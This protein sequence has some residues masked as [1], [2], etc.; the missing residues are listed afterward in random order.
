MVVKETIVA[1]LAEWGLA[2][3]EREIEQLVPAYENLLRWQG[4]LEGMM[5]SKKLVEGMTAPASEP[6]LIHAIERT[7]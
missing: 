3:T 1:R 7:G 4:V 6:I 2:L 5:Q